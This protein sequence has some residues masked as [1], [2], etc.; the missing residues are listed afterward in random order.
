MNPG[1]VDSYEIYG[2]HQ[3]EESEFEEE[4][5]AGGQKKGIRQPVRANRRVRPSNDELVSGE[6]IIEPSKMV[7]KDFQHDSATN[8]RRANRESSSV[9]KTNIEILDHE[10]PLEQYQQYYNQHNYPGNHKMELQA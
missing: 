4:E 7:K 8:P 5:I 3:P 2:E 1:M 9:K 6:Q 10:T